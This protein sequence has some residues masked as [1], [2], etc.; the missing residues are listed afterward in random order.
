MLYVKRDLLNFFQESAILA[1]SA[2][3]PVP[4]PPPAPRFWGAWATLG[5]TIARSPTESNHGH[6]CSEGAACCISF[7]QNYLLVQVI[8]REGL[9]IS[10][11]A[12][13]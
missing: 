6:P 8:L 5:G 11:G 1:H 12:L 7:S 2:G 4:A 13:C 9:R 3:A 10:I